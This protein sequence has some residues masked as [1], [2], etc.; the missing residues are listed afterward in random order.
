MKILTNYDFNG[1]EIQNVKIQNL[2]S[3]PPSPTKGMIYFNTTL[4]RA[5]IFNGEDWEGADAKDAKMTGADIV[6]AI[7][8]SSGIIDND[9]LSEEVNDAINKRH[10]SHSISDVTGLQTALDGKVNNSRVLTDVPEN[11]LFTDT[12]TT[13]NGK[14]GVIT[15]SDITALGIPG[16]DTTYN[17]FTN[18]VDGLVPSSGGGTT[19][20]LRADG[21]WAVP[22]DT[23]YTLP[24]AG[25]SLG[26]VKTGGDVTINANGEISVNDNSHNHIISNID[27]LQST[28]DAK[29][30]VSHTHTSSEITDFNEATQDAIGA[31]LT[32]TS[33]ID[34]TYNDTNN[35]IK[36]DVK[37]NSSNQK[38]AISKN[39]VTPTGTR[40][41]IN[42]KD[43]TNIS[44]TVADN[45]T[46]DVV[47][48]TI[49]NTYTHP[50][51]D[52]NLH[53]PATGTT[54][55]GKV[56]KA[57]S[58]AGSLSWGTLSKS[59]V[60]LGNV[61]NTADSAKSVLSAAKLTTPRT[62]SLTGDVTGSVS[63]D[64]S[65]NVTITA[66]VA[67]DSHNHTIENITG[68]QNELNSKETPAGASAKASVAE[69]NAK[70]YT[71]SKIAELIGSAPET[72]DTLYEIAE[73]LGSDPN[74]ATTILTSLAE[75]TKKYTQQI[76]NG[77]NTVIEVSHGL[78]SRDVIVQLRETASPYAVVMTDVEMTTTNKITLR[79][80]KAPA[81]NEYTVTIIG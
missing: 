60:G 52:G 62:I 19:K 80:A 53:V 30:S 51:G 37:P 42:F 11:A 57:G 36:A 41:Q 10:S 1:N 68:L 7:N 38:V 23:K 5:F 26:G 13:I 4:N 66:T 54:N 6:T 18:T 12:I 63:F 9:R 40:K 45:A 25:T 77:S 17:I 70:E 31:I 14:T 44:V 34:F 49:T 32:D 28:L 16:Q 43:G 55:N 50:T 81:T 65:A 22:P 78:G 20:Y 64:G 71:D 29:A 15:K 46:N 76:G 48:V 61:D 67:D 21:S 79:F 47:D 3:P 73:A 8:N 24:V 56:L 39:S 58:M 2:A 59:D 72:L 35:Q 74:F 27:N 33:T 75:K 69:N